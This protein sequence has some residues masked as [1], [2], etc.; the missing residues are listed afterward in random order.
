[1]DINTIDLIKK[2]NLSAINWIQPVVY[3][4]DTGIGWIYDFNFSRTSVLHFDPII[5][6]L[7]QLD[8][9]IG[10]R[11]WPSALPNLQSVLINLR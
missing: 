5:F 7:Q 9:S 3:N 6:F 8:G 11:T 4:S 1:M 10:K 2:E